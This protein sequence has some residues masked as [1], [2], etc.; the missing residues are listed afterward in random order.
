MGIVGRTFQM[1][2]NAGACIQQARLLA[3][4]CAAAKMRFRGDFGKAGPRHAQ[5]EDP[6]MRIGLGQQLLRSIGQAPPGSE[7]N[8]KKQRCGQAGRGPNVPALSQLA[9]RAIAH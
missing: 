4:C 7:S 2:L 9:R 3:A 1:A 5:I 8:S 6:G